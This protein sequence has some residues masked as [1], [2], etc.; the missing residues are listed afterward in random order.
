MKNALLLFLAMSVSVVLYGQRTVSGTVTNAEGE[1]LIG[2]NVTVVG[3]DGYGTITDFDGYYELQIPETADALAVTY[4]GY[5]PTKIELGEGNEYSITLDDSG[6]VMDEVVVVAYGEQARRSLVSSVSTLD[7]K[8]VSNIP[9]VSPQEV[10][11]GQASGVQIVQSSGVLGAATNIRIRG[12]ASLSAGGQPLF[13]VDGVPLNDGSSGDYSNDFGGATTL[14]PLMN[15]SM[16]D[17]ESMSVLK[18][19][20][21][22]SLYGSRGSNGVVLITTKQGKAGESNVTFNTSYGFGGPTDLYDMTNSEE[23]YEISE[24]YTGNPAPEDPNFFDW[25]DAVVQQAQA[26]KANLGFDGGNDKTRYYIGGA[27]SDDRNYVFGNDMNKYTGKMNLSHQVSDNFKVGA[28]ISISKVNMDRINQENSTFAPLTSAYLQPPF[29]DAYNEDGSYARTGFIANVIAINDIGLSEYITRRNFG[30]A[31]L[32]YTI[33]N[34]G[35]GS[36]N[37][38]SD[39][40]IDQFQT[41]ETIRWPEEISPGG[42]GYKRVIQDDKWLT[43]N[44]IDYSS[45]LGDR[46][47][48][49]VLFGQSFETALFQ[50]IAVEGSGFAADPLRNVSSAAN[51]SITSAT[52]TEW[53]LASFFGR[54]QYDFDD[55]VFVEASFRRDG[56]SRFGANNRW[57]N[58]WAV[59]AGW[60]LSNESFMKDQTFFDELKLRASYGLTG[61]ERIDNFQSL[62]LFGAGT[63]SDY[64]GSPGLRPI[65]PANPDLKWEQTAQ[66]DFGVNMRIKNFFDLGISLWQKN[67]TDLILPFTVPQSTGFTSIV[68]NAGEMINRGIDI[69][70]NFDVVRDRDWYVSIGGNIS[71]LQNEIT[72]LPD[73]TIDP[74]GNQFI[75]GS[76]SQRAVVGRTANE[77][78]L[79][80]YNGI[81]SETGDAEWLTKE[82]EATTTPGQADRV[83]VGSA[84]PDFIG[85]VNFNVSYKDLSL[86]GLF[87]YTYGNLVMLDGLRFTENPASGFNRSTRL[88][89]AWENPGDNAFA[90]GAESST[91]S[92]FAQRSTSQ[93]MDGS[94]LR[95]RTLTLSYNLPVQ[96]L[97]IDWIKSLS[98]YAR[99]N[100]LLTITDSDFRGQDPEVSD[101]GVSNLIQGESFF[102]IP[103][104]KMYTFGL[105]VTF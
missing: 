50:S 68:R 93:L 17:I 84:I 57:G 62:G 87:N 61:N 70:Y 91:V 34:V 82:G 37:I 5:K 11:Q 80:R 32:N 8:A 27:Y 77:F 28:N 6:I 75:P 65:Q 88:L 102:V 38:R 22:T 66:V 60:N 94:F 74:D 81:N 4:I 20:A 35:A 48:F 43:T 21:A 23:Y 95:L 83:F 55:R 15:I 79:I 103:Q 101:S 63:V 47:N 71:F 42:Y 10:L 64:N 56:S 97:G 67:T 92:S 76:A 51:P 49:T 40:G 39:W 52:R 85:G 104:R 25:Q 69:D 41:E 14:N 73:A 105:N 90:P 2:A 33:P 86:S 36:I 58:F 7:D 89:D 53:A 24:R 3:E 16:E 30:N 46:S 19:A 72:E 54:A 13:V 98:I 78:F 96:S 18:D 59:G 44:T 12:V 99:G 45:P 26:F 29:V 31:Y 1:P 100:N 9:A